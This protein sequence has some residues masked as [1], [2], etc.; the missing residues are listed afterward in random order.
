MR[1]SIGT[2]CAALLLAVANATAAYP[3][4]PIRWIIDFPAAG[5]SDILARTVGQRLS[6]RL[7]QSIVYDNRPG[8]NGIIANELV[9]KNPPDGYTAGFISQPCTLKHKTH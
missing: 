9:A 8:A 6:E 7:G 2:V 3:D 4:K 5:D 1:V